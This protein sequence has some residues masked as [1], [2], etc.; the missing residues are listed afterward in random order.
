ML[1]PFAVTPFYAALCGLLLLALSVNVARV[2]RKYR[3]YI[4]NGDEIG[5]LQAI[6]VQAN[7]IEYV[8]LCLLLLF[9]LELSRQPAWALH[10][11]GAALVVGRIL[12]AIGLGSRPG[13]SLGRFTGTGLTWIMLAAASVWLLVVVL[14]RYLQMAPA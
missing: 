11:L 1:P 6:R 7:F 12:H 5:L 4:G 13:I 10:L 14:Q 2:R 8:P 9:L 3:V